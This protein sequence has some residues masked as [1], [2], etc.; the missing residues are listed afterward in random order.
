MKKVYYKIEFGLLSPL[1]LSSGENEE[2]DKDLMKDSR[3]IPYI[4]ASSVAGVCRSMLKAVLS[5]GEENRYFGDLETGSSRVIFYDATLKD[6]QNW[7]LSVRDSVKLDEWKTAVKGAKFDMEVLEPGVSFT[8]YIEQNL[9]EEDRDVVRDIIARMQMGNC[10]FGAKTMRGYGQIGGIQVGCKSFD[11]ADAGETKE[12]LIFDM[13]EGSYDPYT[14]SPSGESSEHSILLGL[15]QRG[16]ISIRKYSTR[17]S[18]DKKRYAEPDYE[19]LTVCIGNDQIPVIPGT[20][21]NG[22]FRHRM[23]EL[24]LTDTDQLFGYVG[25]KGSM[26]SKIRFS[27]TQLMG[28]KEKV[29]SRNAIDRFS[30]GTKDGALYTER[31]YYNG[32]G[33]LRIS[34]P[35]E[36]GEEE[37]RIL[38]AT[39]CDLHFGYLSVGGL[40]SVGRGMFEITKIGEDSIEATDTYAGQLYQRILQA[41]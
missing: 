10:Y 5:K 24:G 32:E 15:K 8:T 29:L 40:T 38:A 14:E 18:K 34:Y 26:R 33:E 31:T 35:A 25:A 20:S 1:A 4:P 16:G 39:I 28:A 23:T 17:P 12:W 30:G 9:V 22:A 13:Y 19:Q 7:R 21:W 36:I 27:E 37:K 41:L 11:L 6:G 3:G 2:T